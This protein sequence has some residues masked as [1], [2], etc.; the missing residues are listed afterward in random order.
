MKVQLATDH[1]EQSCTKY[2]EIWLKKISPEI[3]VWSFEVGHFLFGMH[4][5]LE[6]EY[7]PYPFQA[8]SKVLECIRIEVVMSSWS[9]CKTIT[10]SKKG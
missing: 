4:A 6:F 8:A 9:T 3:L 7:H 5:P 10:K 2:V 1:T